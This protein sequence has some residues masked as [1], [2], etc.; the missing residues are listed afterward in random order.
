MKCHTDL[1]SL[2]DGGSLVNRSY[3]YRAGNWFND[4]LND[5]LEAFSFTPPPPGGTSH[6]LSDIRSFISTRW[7]YTSDSNPCSACHNPHAA[8]GDPANSGSSP[9]SAATRGLPVSRPSLHSFDNNAWGLWGDTGEKMS[10][11]AGVN[12]QAPYRYNT[13]TFYEPDGSVT[14]NGSNLTDFVTFCTDCH[15]DTNII[16]SSTMGT[17]K[18]IDWNVST[19]EK[20]GKVDIDGTKSMDA[21]YDTGGTV[22]AC[23]DCHEPHGSP[24]EA[25]I[26]PEVNGAVLGATVD[27]ISSSDICSPPTGPY[28]DTN[29]T[30]AGLCNRCHQDDNESNASCG[31]NKYYIIHHDA[32]SCNCCHYH[33]SEVDPGDGGG[34]RKTF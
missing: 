27:S 17:L 32:A 16:T 8:Q 33:R 29:K 1:S 22:L 13:S 24:N 34:I 14:T 23:T 21:P 4:T 30:V 20:H 25:L 10:D 15:D 5:I 18:T 12:Y 11:Y 2:Q 31:T 28:N 9:K 3:S 7:N 26:R 6:N 19:G